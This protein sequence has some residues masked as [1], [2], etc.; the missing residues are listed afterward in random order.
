MEAIL[1]NWSFM[2][3]LR[4]GVG[5]WM[6][7]TAIL[8]RQPVIGLMAVMFLIQALFN[9]GCVGGACNLPTTKETITSKPENVNFEEVK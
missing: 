6:A 8:D 2:R 4:L 5:L 9:M 3:F 1:K 7:Y